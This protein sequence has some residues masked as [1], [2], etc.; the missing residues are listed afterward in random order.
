M[1]F[2]SL[3]SLFFYLVQYFSPCL[4]SASSP[5][6]PES[7]WFCAKSNVLR[8]RWSRVWILVLPCSRSVTLVSHLTSQDGNF[9]IE[10]KTPGAVGGKKSTIKG[11][12]WVLHIPEVKS[13]DLTDLP[14]FS[15]KHHQSSEVNTSLLPNYW[16]ISEWRECF[17][18]AKSLC[19]Q[20][21]SPD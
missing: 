7:P 16:R 8:V 2:N 17:L 1:P 21:A 14:S 6:L 5:L 20:R 15:W 3:F 4:H 12:L 13:L 18:S 9:L 19:A 10:R 11:M